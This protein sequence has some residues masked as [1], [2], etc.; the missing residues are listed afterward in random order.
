MCC[1]WGLHAVHTAPGNTH[2]NEREDG[3]AVG[4]FREHAHRI[5]SL[6]LGAAVE[7]SHRIACLVPVAVYAYPPRL[8][9]QRGADIAPPGKRDQDA[10]ADQGLFQGDS[11]PHV[12]HS[13]EGGGGAV[14][15]VAAERGFAF[16]C[17]GGWW[18]CTDT[19]S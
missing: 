18:P 15:A 1:R 13:L 8:F 14:L 10:A 3:I 12:G 11:S 16:R 17:F 9:P 6:V 7:P 2:L 19:H 5:D 4:V